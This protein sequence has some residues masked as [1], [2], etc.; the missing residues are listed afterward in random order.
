MINKNL[1]HFLSLSLALSQDLRLSHHMVISVIN[2]L[3]NNQLTH[4]E[5]IELVNEMYPSLPKLT[6]EHFD[7]AMT[8]LEIHKKNNIECISIWDENYPYTL[9]LIKN[10]PSILYLKGDPNILTQ[11]PGVAVVGTRQVTHNGSIIAKRLSAYLAANNWTIVSG[12]AIGVDSF[13][14]EGALSVNGKTIAVLANGLH[15][16]S[17]KQNAL[18]A[19]EIL[20]K[21]GA[22]VSEHPWGV[23]PRKEYFVPRNRI[24]IGLSAGSIIVESEIKSGTATQA[25]FCIQANRPL[26]AVVPHHPDNPLSLMCNG[27]MYLVEHKN[28]VPILTKDDYPTVISKLNE[29]RSRL[30]KDRD[31]FPRIGNV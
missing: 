29:S 14:H 20:L 3:P 2:S 19:D 30:I 4:L 21:G 7:N 12:L 5:L 27:P 25:E 24:Q 28:A 1:N 18:L 22:W 10:P 15:K 17:P 31:L 26:F 8:L 13:A 11:L 9:S 6:L 23:E 16:A